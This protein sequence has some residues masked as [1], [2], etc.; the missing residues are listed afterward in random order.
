MNAVVSITENYLLEV[1]AVDLSL[2]A[3]QTAACSYLTVQLRS[4]ASVTD[5]VNMVIAKCYPAESRV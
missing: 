2:R 3:D 4:S 5:S 1:T